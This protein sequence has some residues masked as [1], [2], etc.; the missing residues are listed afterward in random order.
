MT[1]SNIGAKTFLG[2]IVAGFVM[3]GGRNAYGEEQIAS[4]VK[5]KA[6][7]ATAALK[8]ATT[9]TLKRAN[10]TKEDYEM[11]L[12][13]ELEALKPKIEELKK[14][15]ATLAEEAR[16]KAQE[17]MVVLEKKRAELEVKLAKFSKKSEKAWAEM[18]TGLDAAVDDLKKAYDEAK[19]KFKQP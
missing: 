19:E 11:R 15:T 12:K 9:T 8:E 5:A 14:Q 13:E 10:E 18:K 6:T 2:V 17:Q 16:T 1:L 4:H 3:M 7:K